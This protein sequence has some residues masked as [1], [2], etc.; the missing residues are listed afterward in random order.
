MNGNLKRPTSI[1]EMEEKKSNLDLE[2]RLSGDGARI[3]VLP[4]TLAA[5]RAERPTG[6]P[7]LRSRSAPLTHFGEAQAAQS[8]ADF[9]H[10]LRLA[11]KRLRKTGP[12]VKFLERAQIFKSSEKLA[13][14]LAEADQLVRLFVTRISTA[15]IRRHS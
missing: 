8:L 9:T 3:I 14:L 1:I 7:L 11:L 15:E 4:R 2:N 12:W 6:N 13:S 10:N 5:Y